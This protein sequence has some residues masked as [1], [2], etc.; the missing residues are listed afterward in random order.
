VYGI[1]DNKVAAQQTRKK[2]KLSYLF[3]RVFLPYSQM[4][5]KYPR[6]QK[7]PILY[8]FYIIKRCFLLLNKEKR[9]LAFREVD[10]TVNGDEKQQKVAKLMRNLEL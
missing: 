9:T 8:P 5:F 7:C 2:S 3:S 10:Q 1:F 4:R 6:L